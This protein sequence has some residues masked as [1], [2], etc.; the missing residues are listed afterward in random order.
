M[1][2]FRVCLGGNGEAGGGGWKRPA[3][4]GNDERSYLSLVVFVAFC[5]F[6]PPSRLFAI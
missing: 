5:F 6:P 4:G 3:K 1:L 2:G